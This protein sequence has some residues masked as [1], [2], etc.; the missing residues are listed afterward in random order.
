MVERAAAGRTERE[1]P[2]PTPRL[3]PGAAD[4]ATSAR[5]PGPWPAPRRRAARRALDVAALVLLLGLAVLTR[6]GALWRSGYSPDEEISVF[7]VRGIASTGLPRLPSGVLYDRGLAFSYSAWACGRL[8]GDVLPSYRIPSIA[9]GLA[10]IVLTAALARRLGGSFLLAGSLATAATWLVAA[11]TWARS[12]AMF[13]AAFL[14]TA[15]TL[16]DS[17]AGGSRRGRWFLAGLAATRLLHETGVVLV[18][19]PLFLLLQSGPGSPERRR[20]R[21]LSL[22]SVALLAV[23]QLVLAAF[24]PAGAAFAAPVPL[25]TAAG[26]PRVVPALLS[27]SSPTGLALL[28]LAA[29]GLGLLLR[30]LGASWVCC[31]LAAGCSATLNLGLLAVGT[32]ALM[33]ARPARG[34]ATAAAGLAIGLATLA[35]WSV[36]VWRYTAAGWGWSVTGSLGSAGLVFPLSALTALAR[37]WPLATGAAL[38]GLVAGWRRWRVRSLASLVLAS[39]VLLGV[40]GLG[41]KP[42]YF[43]GVFPLLFAMAATLPAALGE[44]L[45]RAGWLG[46]AASAGLALALLG[47]L[48]VEQERRGRDPLLESGADL[49]QARL[50]TSPQ[51]RWAAL[52]GRRA[53]EGPLVCNDDL[54]CLLL[55]RTPS[56]WWLGTQA[57]AAEYGFRD[58]SGWRSVYTG[59]PIVVGGQ[60]AQALVSEDPRDPSVIVLDTGKYAVTRGDARLAIGRWFERACDREGMLL[61]RAPHADRAGPGPAK[62]RDPCTSD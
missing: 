13:V 50:R 31:A 49:L 51:E 54:A 59:V 7:A 45:R 9:A 60:A 22:Q 47:S 37:R 3:G 17:P 14:A 5:Q 18:A 56:Y 30:R 10:S 1:A 2:R 40:I 32:V 53:L 36:Y 58:G 33:L 42:R 6:W 12:Y 44:R 23:L 8:F 20:S 19:L 43:L 11:S 27:Q 46:Q 4:A 35:F 48:L 15:L 38:A 29:V 57:E 26:A 34:P 55:G 61:F 39:V 62:E 24:K 16:L 25:A 21:R 52:L 41:P 28:G